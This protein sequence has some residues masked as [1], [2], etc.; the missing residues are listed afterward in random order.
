MHVDIQLASCSCSR[1]RIRHGWMP[2]LQLYKLIKT[3]VCYIVTYNLSHICVS[4]ILCYIQIEYRP[5]QGI[6]KQGKGLQDFY[7]D[8]TLSVA[9]L[10]FRTLCALLR[11]CTTLRIQCL[12]RYFQAE[13]YLD[14][15]T[16]VPCAT[17]RSIGLPELRH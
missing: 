13:A 8:I 16:S 14:A 1:S 6:K 12:L 17:D 3:K 10:Y 7:A 5:G 15:L 11:S 2:W 4:Y 9:I